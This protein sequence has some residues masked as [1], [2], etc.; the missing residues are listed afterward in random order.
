MNLHISPAKPFNLE[1][2]GLPADKSLSHRALIFALLC[3]KP[4]FVENLLKGADCLSTLNIVK[5]LGLKVQKHGANG[6]KLTPPKKFL[7]FNEPAK[8][9][10][11]NNSGTSMRLLSGLLS[12][13]QSQQNHY[14]LIGDKS[15]SQRPMGRV[16]K[17]LAQMGAQIRAR[18]QNLAPLSVLSAPL[19]GLNYAS[20]IASA[21]VKSALLLASLQAKD[22]L[23]FSEPHLSRD[24]S[25]R[26]LLALGAPIKLTPPS[27]TL[28]PLQKPLESFSWSIP[29]DPSSAFYFALAVVLVP[30]SSILLKGVLLNPSRIEAFKVLEQ[31]GA[32]VCYQQ[33]GQMGAEP[34][35]DIYIQHSPLKAVSISTNIASLIDELPALAVAM[36]VAKGVSVVA[37]AEELRFKES[38]RIATT[39]SN[40][41]KMGIKC[42]PQP[43]GFSITGGGFKRPK[44][45][46]ESFKDHRIALSFAMALLS[47][48]GDL[49]GLECVAISFPHF[50]DLLECITHFKEI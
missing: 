24:H 19:K 22:P 36:S 21:Q 42:K 13:S 50:L 30:N 49:K 28:E 18:A 23:H 8:P 16:I 17:P 40:L 31:M 6:L 14:I 43:D 46:L 1:L 29:A 10:N 35:G 48:G 33:R 2:E 38:D 25:E 11:C 47:C 20:P 34:I 4:C 12:S 41:A 37:N 7:H 15:L 5:T 27:L 39:L 45:P 9:L 32:I 44:E 3:E 26:A